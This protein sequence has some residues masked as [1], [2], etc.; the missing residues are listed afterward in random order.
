MNV[1]PQNTAFGIGKAVA[2]P[3]R[4]F[5]L[6]CEQTR[7]MCSIVL[8]HSDRVKILSSQKIMSFTVTGAEADHLTAQF[9]NLTPGHFLWLSSDRKMRL[10]AEP[11]HFEF[12]INEGGISSDSV[13]F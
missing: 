4:D 10:Q 6:V 13:N 9:L 7:N 5:S 2:A 8:N 3:A 1:P 12:L 11:G